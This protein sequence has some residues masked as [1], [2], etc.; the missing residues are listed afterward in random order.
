MKNRQPTGLPFNLLVSA[1]IVAIIYLVHLLI[2]HTMPAILPYVFPAILVIGM[3]G[4]VI[5]LYRLRMN[6]PGKPMQDFTSTLWLLTILVIAIAAI[7]VFEETSETPEWLFPVMLATIVLWSVY[8]IFNQ[9]QHRIDE[10]DYKLKL[11]QE[12]IKTL[13][14]DQQANE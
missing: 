11:Q 6:I 8:G 1:V 5:Y 4:S 9:Q 12:L 13:R 10:L 14:Q 7:D 2:Q 3:I